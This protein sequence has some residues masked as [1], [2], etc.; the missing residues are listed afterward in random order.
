VK[1]KHGA[2]VGQLDQ[3]ALFYLRSR[4]IAESEATALLLRGFGQEV[5]ERV[6]HPLIQ[7][8]LDKRMMT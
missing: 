7:A 1:C 8:Y 5:I 4:G 6:K 2:T 3:D